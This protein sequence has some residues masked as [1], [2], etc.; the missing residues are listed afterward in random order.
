MIRTYHA[1]CPLGVEEPLAEELRQ[2]GVRQLR[3]RKG[4]VD[5][6]GDRRLAYRACLWVRCC[7]RIQEQL[8]EGPV[9]EGKDLYDLARSVSWDRFTGPDRT[10]SVHA[11]GRHPAF[12]DTR[13]PALVIKDAVCDSLRDRTGRRPFVDRQNADLPLRV[14]LGDGSARLYRDLAGKSLHKRGWRPVQVKSP[15][16]EALAA[17]LLRLAGWDGSTSLLDPMCG[18][19]TF[20]VEAAMMAADRAP[21]LG[22]RFALERWLDHD[23]GLFRDLRAGRP[24]RGGGRPGPV[25]VRRRGTVHP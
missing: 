24:C 2:L 6:R 14:H 5:F 18:S 23:A 17:G 13:Y 21:G 16:N 20:V 4:A 1:P 12:R 3:V 10:L 22:R 9:R 7:I 8:A 25:P 19:G 15:L 11:S